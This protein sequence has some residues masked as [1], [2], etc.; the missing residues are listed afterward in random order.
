MNTTMDGAW[1]QLDQAELRLMIKR[2]EGHIKIESRPHSRLVIWWDRYCTRKKMQK[3]LQSF[4]PEVLKDFGLT[5]AEA[6]Q[7]AHKPFW[8]A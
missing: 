3:E 7:E 8:R 5:R 6:W 4:T 2:H 1:R